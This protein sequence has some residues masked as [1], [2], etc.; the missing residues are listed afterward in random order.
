M[1][2]WPL[3]HLLTKGTFTIVI[4][5]EDMLRDLEENKE[6]E[7]TGMLECSLQLNA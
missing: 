7:K 4:Q 3:T 5:E 2:L 1:V 6:K